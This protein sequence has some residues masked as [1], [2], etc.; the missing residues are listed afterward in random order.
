MNWQELKR[1]YPGIWNDVYNGMM[2]TF[3]EINTK[4]H[5]A[6]AHNAAFLACDSID[7][8]LKVR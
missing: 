5:K 3:I 6:I 4:D 7:K 2:D 8:R 1:K